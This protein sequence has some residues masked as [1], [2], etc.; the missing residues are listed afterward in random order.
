MG[1]LSDRCSLSW[2][3]RRPFIIAGAIGVSISLIALAFVENFIQEKFD[4]LT[5]ATTKT[6]IS[7][8]MAIALICCIHISIQPV[9]VGMR[10]LIVEMVPARQ[11]AQATAWTTCLIG[12]GNIFGFFL[13][14]I[15]IATFLGIK[16]VSEFQALALI[17][18]IAL[19]TTTTISCVAGDETSERAARDAT[20]KPKPKTLFNALSTL[21]Q[22]PYSIL[23]VYKIQFFA[24][25]AWFPMLYYKS[26]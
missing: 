24:W 8:A 21:E 5:D 18:S 25:I 6:T 13:G 2:G 10:S 14:S 16:S 1:S 17:S 22:L 7:H 20:P 4:N 15:D 19:L 9:Q 11:Q 3:K 23:R 26:T 12:F